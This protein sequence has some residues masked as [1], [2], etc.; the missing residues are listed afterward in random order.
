MLPPGVSR[1]VD[2]SQ[3]QVI[4][5]N[6]QSLSLKVTDLAAMDAR[7]VYKSTSYD[8]RNYKRLQLFS[9]AEALSPDMT[10]LSSGDLAVF[11]RLGSD[12]KNNY[13][14]YEVPLEVTPPGTYSQNNSSHREIVWPE[15]NRMDF[16]LE[17]LTDLKL[18]RNR[19]KRQ[20]P[21]IRLTR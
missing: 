7:A 3:S 2:P 17:V 18:E 15:S 11:I 16:R 1:V 9:H 13:Y 4:Q 20:I 10:G 12:Y 21:T 19:E 14:E 6:E 8:L 5:E